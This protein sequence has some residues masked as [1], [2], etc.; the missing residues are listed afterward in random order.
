MKA[1]ELPQRV[2]DYLFKKKV[3]TMAQSPEVRQDIIT[4][5]LAVWTDEWCLKRQLMQY[6]QKKR[7]NLA[8]DPEMNKVD[9]YVMNLYG[10]LKEGE[11]LSIKEVQALVKHYYKFVMTSAKIKVIRQRVYNARRGKESADV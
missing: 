10:N 3:L 8:S 11:K 2:I 6:P 7:L 9:W 1:K 4:A 5:I